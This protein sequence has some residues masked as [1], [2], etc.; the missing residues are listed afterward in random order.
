VP[1]L[2]LGR[3]ALDRNNREMIDIELLAMGIDGGYYLL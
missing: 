2:D 1:F 3:V